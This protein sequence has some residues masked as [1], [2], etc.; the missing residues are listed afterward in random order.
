MTI[1]IEQVAG[2]SR[3]VIDEVEKAIVGKRV[4]LED[5]LVSFLCPGGHV[6]L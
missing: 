2:L 4:V 1:A 5:I 3:Q 6:L